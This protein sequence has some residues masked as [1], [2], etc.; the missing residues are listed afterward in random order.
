MLH[1]FALSCCWISAD[2]L[3]VE[4]GH[5]QEVVA[6]RRGV[7]LHRTSSRVVRSTLG[8]RDIVLKGLNTRSCLDD[9]LIL[10]TMLVVVSE[11]SCNNVIVL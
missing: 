6:L 4:V 1:V 7:G 8:L 3:H 11:N 9:S 5:L 10:L 2:V